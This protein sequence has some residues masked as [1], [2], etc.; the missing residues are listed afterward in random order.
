MKI[1]ISIPRVLLF[2]TVS[3]SANLTEKLEQG[4]K[5]ISTGVGPEAL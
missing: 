5:H 3:L 2:F 1:R 4:E